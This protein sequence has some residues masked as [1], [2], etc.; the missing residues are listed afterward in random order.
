MSNH[1]SA[2]ECEAILEH[3]ASLFG[4]RVGEDVLPPRPNPDG[5]FPPYLMIQFG[6]PVPKGSDRGLGTETAQPHVLPILMMVVASDSKTARTG[7]T[8]VINRYLGFVPGGGG[9]AGAL[10]GGSGAAFPIKNA[11]GATVR[12]ERVLLYECVLN[13]SPVTQ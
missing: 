12:V 8:A 13:L 1:D 9:N 6:T 11:A 5:S 7:A 10:T 3:G 2:A 4:G